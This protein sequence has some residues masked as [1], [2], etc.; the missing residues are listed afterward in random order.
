M[1]AEPETPVQATVRKD[2]PTPDQVSAAEAKRQRVASPMLDDVVIQPLLLPKSAS[3]F[4]DEAETNE[5]GGLTKNVFQIS[6][7][8]VGIRS[9]V[10]KHESKIEAII[11]QRYVGHEPFYC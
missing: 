8:D 1:Q 4:N 5:Q 9:Y 7:R 10:G 2:P 11:K 3:L 6:E